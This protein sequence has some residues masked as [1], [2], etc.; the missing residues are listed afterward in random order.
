MNQPAM[1]NF[2]GLL[3]RSAPALDAATLSLL[4]WALFVLVIGFLCWLWWGKREAL[5]IQHVGIAVTL[6][7][8][9]SPHLHLHDLSLLLLPALGAVALLWERG[10][11]GRLAALALLPASALLLFANDLVKGPMHF[12]A[13]YALML[14]LLVGLSWSLRSAAQSP[15]GTVFE[16]SLKEIHATDS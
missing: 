16:R 11:N 3:I 7:L 14:A 15:G 9:A 10:R 5:T 4:K 1:Y 12:F 2:L 8:F 6:S 13:G